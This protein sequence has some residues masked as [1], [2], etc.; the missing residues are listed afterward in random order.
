MN[1]KQIAINVVIA[2]AFFFIGGTVGAYTEH[3]SSIESVQPATETPTA[4]PQN[5]SKIKTVAL[6]QE[7]VLGNITMKVV[8]TEETQSINNE[9]GS[10]TAGGKFIV[11]ELELKNNDKQAIEYA[12]KQFML[13]S[14]DLEYKIDDAS[15]DAMGNLNNQE[16]IYNKNQEFIGVYDS[17]NPGMVKKTYLVFDV[18]KDVTLDN[19]KLMLTD[20][21]EIQFSLK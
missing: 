5:E 8:K 11:I 13:K 16:S 20:N 6:N 18:P 2:V 9:S 17:F 21:N 4:K 12:A 14:K 19:A 15:F 1:K 7:E 3:Q 10:S